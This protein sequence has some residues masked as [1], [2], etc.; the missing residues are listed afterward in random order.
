[1]IVQDKLTPLTRE[2]ATRA[3]LTAYKQL[4][5]ALPSTA[6]LALLVA[7]SA[8]ETGHWK[9]LHHFNFGNAKAGPGYPLITQFR[10]S[11][12]DAQ[13]VEHFYDPP[14]PQCNFRAYSD[15]AAGALDYLKVL[16]NRPHW[17][18][19]LHTADPGAF[20]DALATA[21]KYFTGNVGIYKRSII[22]LFKS[23][24]P[25]AEV[26]LAMA[27]AMP[28]V[29]VPVVPVVPAPSSSSASSPPA[30][31][32][33]PSVPPSASSQ[34]GQPPSTPREPP[35]KSATPQ[36]PTQTERTVGFWQRL[37]DFLRGFVELLF[38]SGQPRPPGEGS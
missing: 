24:F 33:A 16:R 30:S 21:P 9:S 11:E 1:M 27:A 22:S 37:I 15:A 2:E 23:F 6:V 28:A 38:K 5:G 7:Q 31:S 18:S 20:V 12:V 14:H 26:A 29:P 34:S 35:K 4:T 10:C 25:L 19:G 3:L 13:G 36:V 32:G 17:W 8:F